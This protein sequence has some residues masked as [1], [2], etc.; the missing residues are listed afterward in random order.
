MADTHP[1]T[2]LPRLLALSP[3]DLGPRTFPEFLARAEASFNAGLTGL[4]LR[5]PGLPDGACLELLDELLALRRR[6]DF[7]AWIGV[8][9]RAHLALLRP[10]D[11]L[12]LGGR[13][14][15]PDVAAELLGGRRALGFS[16]HEG[17]DPEDL[18]TCD[19]LFFSPV[20]PT[21]SKPGAPGVGW[22]RLAAFTT[23]TPAPVLALGGM[24]PED[25][26]LALGHGA[27]GVACLS[28]LVNAADPAGSTRAFLEAFEE[29]AG[30]SR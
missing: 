1:R 10:C 2:P 13:S 18:H 7:R 8:H 26:G 16:A 5:E 28:A 22:E 3:G 20:R 23:R 12:H 9:D 24:R 29:T 6:G 21:A 30:G 27:H 19:Y 17:D 4:L 11:G 14:L 25:V 15:R